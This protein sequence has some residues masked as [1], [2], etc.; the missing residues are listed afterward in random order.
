MDFFSSIIITEDVFYFLL[1]LKSSLDKSL[2]L[3]EMI[4]KDIENCE[5]VHDDPLIGQISFDDLLAEIR[6]WFRDHTV[7]TKIEN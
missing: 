5:A 2:Y 3:E 6:C 1:V 7:N 4:E